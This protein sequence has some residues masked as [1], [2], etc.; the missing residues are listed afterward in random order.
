MPVHG[1][2][3]GASQQRRELISFISII[4]AFCILYI[5]Q[6][7]HCI[8]HWSI[9][10]S[11]CQHDDGYMDGRSQ[12]N[13]HTDEWTDID[14]AQSSVTVTHPSTNRAWRYLTSVTESTS[15]HWSPPRTSKLID[16]GFCLS[17]WLCLRSLR[18]CSNMSYTLDLCNSC[19]FSLAPEPVIRH[20][21][22]AQIELSC[23]DNQSYATIAS[24]SN[25]IHFGTEIIG[26][27]QATS[28]SSTIYCRNTA[29]PTLVSPI[30]VSLRSLFNN[31]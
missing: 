30:R 11:P 17:P 18:T 14:N 29:E 5:E 10:L 19:C 2:I 22:L 24:H 8:L 7:A 6:F 3:L 1:Y 26:K 9:D 31:S 16:Y 21:R 4:I 13:V 15:K 28:E 23:V 20:G 12:I 25:C 27:K